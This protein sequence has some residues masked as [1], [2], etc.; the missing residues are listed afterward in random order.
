MAHFNGPVVQQLVPSMAEVVKV[1]GSTGYGNLNPQEAEMLKSC[2]AEI[3]TS[4]HALS[5]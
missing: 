4:W 3:F 2:G 5:R 1:E